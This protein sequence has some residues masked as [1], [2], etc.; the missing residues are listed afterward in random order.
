MQTNSKSSK[1]WA[2]KYCPMLGKVIIAVFLLMDKQVQANLIPWSAT[3]PI[4]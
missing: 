1:K 3:E 4:K 2:C